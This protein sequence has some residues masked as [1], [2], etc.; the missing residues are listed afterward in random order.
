MQHTSLFEAEF[1]TVGMSHGMSTTTSSS[2][3]ENPSSSSATT[4]TTG[5]HL[6]M[7]PSSC[8]HNLAHGDAKT[9]CTEVGGQWK[10]AWY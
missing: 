9:M 7:S 3:G 4:T 2:H 10:G 5:H 8:A 1:V 6:W